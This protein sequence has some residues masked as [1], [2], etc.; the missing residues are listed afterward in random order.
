MDDHGR[1]WKE[2]EDGEP[3]API[4]SQATKQSSSAGTTRDERAYRVMH[5][6]PEGLP[7]TSTLG[8]DLV[9]LMRA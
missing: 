8:E 7:T 1:G 3:Q 4:T 6:Q 9:R 5:W 2:M